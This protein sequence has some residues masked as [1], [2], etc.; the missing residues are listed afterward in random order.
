MPDFERQ[1]NGA[2][3]DWDDIEFELECSGREAG[4]SGVSFGTVPGGTTPWPAAARPAPWPFA[5]RNL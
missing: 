1:T 5:K 4:I 3:A 2:E